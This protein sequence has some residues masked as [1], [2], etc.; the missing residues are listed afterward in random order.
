M[1]EEKSHIFQVLSDYFK[2]LK[3]PKSCESKNCK[4]GYILE[5]NL[6]SKTEFK[7]QRNLKVRL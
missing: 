4:V 7:L 6:I 3:V 2:I 1:H 5:T